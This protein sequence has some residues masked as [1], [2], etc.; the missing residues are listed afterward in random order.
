M[1]EQCQGP[2]R[3]GHGP[4]P[5]QPR[6]RSSRKAR[7]RAPGGL[8]RNEWWH[9]WV[10]YWKSLGSSGP[11]SQPVAWSRKTRSR[12]AVGSCARIRAL[13]ASFSS[14]RR[15][16]QVPGTLRPSPAKFLRFVGSWDL[17]HAAFGHLTRKWPSMCLRIK[18]GILRAY[19]FLSAHVPLANVQ[20]A[21]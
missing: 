13:P 20:D 7:Q 3:G 6:C 10:P 19:F 1:E 16:A 17:R 5:A 9:R 15:W 18:E 2:H 12:A 21:H 11:Q 8:T 14:P 4:P